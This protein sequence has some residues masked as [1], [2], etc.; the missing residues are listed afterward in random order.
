[1]VCFLLS[2]N[3]PDDG[4]VECA[5]E[6]MDEGTGEVGEEAWTA[7]ISSKLAALRYRLRLIAFTY[8]LQRCLLTLNRTSG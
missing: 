3:W 4:D 5:D 6:M 2:G 1:M 8:I 7:A